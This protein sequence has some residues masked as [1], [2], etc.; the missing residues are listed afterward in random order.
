LLL[1]LLFFFVSFGGGFDLFGNSSH[2]PLIFH[3][4]RA[5]GG[6]NGGG[7]SLGVEWGVMAD[8]LS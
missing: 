1:S 3:V 8:R 2:V 4:G 5:R 7:V 6:G